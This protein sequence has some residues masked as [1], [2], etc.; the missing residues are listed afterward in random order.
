M[1]VVFE[2]SM[3]ME[4]AQDRVQRRCCLFVMTLHDVSLYK[5]SSLMHYTQ[6]IYSFMWNYALLVIKRPEF[7]FSL[8][9]RIQC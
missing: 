3:W 5:L 1:D 9:E 8:S 4:L 6:Q 2:E 7:L